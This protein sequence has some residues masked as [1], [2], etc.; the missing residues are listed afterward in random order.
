MLN[1]AIS[2]TN[3][4]N[5]GKFVDRVGNPHYYMIG[6]LDSK[7]KEFII[8]IEHA[9]EFLHNRTTCFIKVFKTKRPEITVL[10]WNSV[11]DRIVREICSEAVMSL[12]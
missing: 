8:E 4:D 11:S 2:L 9:G 10:N 7:K 12:D 5:T 3:R 1:A 6:A